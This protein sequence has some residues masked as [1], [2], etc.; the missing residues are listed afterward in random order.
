MESAS[1]GHTNDDHAARGPSALWLLVFLA[2]LAGCAG[3]I[4]FSA[5]TGHAATASSE[6]S[7][8]DR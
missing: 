8:A 4:N 7:T 6:S 1:A 5:A 3:Q 2:C